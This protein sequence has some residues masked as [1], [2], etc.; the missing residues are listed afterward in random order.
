MSTFLGKLVR[1]T[2]PAAP[3]PTWEIVA[4]GLRNGAGRSTARRATCT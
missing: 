3:S 4:N 2:N 1:T